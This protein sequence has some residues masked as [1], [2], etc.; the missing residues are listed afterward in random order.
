MAAIAVTVAELE[1]RVE[2][3]FV[4][5]GLDPLQ[6]G[7]VARTIAAGERDGCASH[8]LYRIDGCLA[9]M[10]AGKV[11]LDAKPRLS[12]DGPAIVR[13]EAGG[14]FAPA[15]FELGAPAL[16]EAA[17]EAG[18]AALVVNDCVHFAALWPEVEAMAGMGLAALALC[19]SYSAVAPAG[20]TAALL[21]TNPL[22]FGWPR[23]GGL[24]YVF[25]V[26]TSVVA[27][28]EV[29][30]RRLAGEA[31]PEGWA[32]DA[33]GRPTTDPARALEGAL[34]PFGGHKGS[35][36]STMVELLGG[37]LIGDLT[38]PEAREAMGA[39]AALPRHG[40][41]VLAF[42]PRRLSAGRPGDPFARAEALF[43]AILGQGAR[44]PSERRFA[45]RARSLAQGIA[46]GAEQA[47]R[48]EALARG[49]PG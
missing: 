17:R 38:S 26:A 2:A 23:P 28:G 22:A 18:L 34:L 39:A 33:G 42:D 32:V 35:A 31:I 6:A 46:L 3:I 21:G 20:G 4:A 19:P 8:G 37:A 48:L 41:L 25:D 10:R 16:A 43:S 13:V 7:A 40:E 44:L 12:R 29:E 9:T 36:V 49:G 27:R 45:A 5:A 14:G 11:T 1:R 30:L 15:A 47:A 24:P